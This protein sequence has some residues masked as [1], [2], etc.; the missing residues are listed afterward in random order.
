M[1][2]P[3]SHHPLLNRRVLGPMNQSS[4]S[5]PPHLD[6]PARI[7]WLF[8]QASHYAVTP[9]ELHRWRRSLAPGE[10]LARADQQMK[11]STRLFD[12]ALGQLRA[13]PV[14]Q[15]LAWLSTRLLAHDVFGRERTRR[16]LLSLLEQWRARYP[17]RRDTPEPMFL[18]FARCARLFTGRRALPILEEAVE[19]RR[20]S[21][22]S[23]TL[24]DGLLWLGELHFALKHTE[25][26]AAILA[27]AAR[28][29]PSDPVLF[30]LARVRR[31]LGDHDGAI[32]ALTALR[33][34]R[35]AAV[36]E[37]HADDGAAC[38]ALLMVLDE[39]RQS[40]RPE[41]TDDDEIARLQQRTAKE[42]RSGILP[43]LITIRR[44]VAR[45]FDDR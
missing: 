40:G 27:N 9:A 15:P 13:L 21:P 16:L 10:L 38:R 42:R 44:R 45:S 25:R 33:D 20:Y 5:A 22:A 11:R 4:I 24:Q 3:I 37:H 41:L 18:V 32:D 1:R 17:H 39:L 14:D 6:P 28:L 30:R 31:A 7:D 2:E 34:V 29:G 36:A 8:D 23:W 26:A 19:R 12:A 35:R 43:F